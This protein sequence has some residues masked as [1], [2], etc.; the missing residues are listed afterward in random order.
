M[1][2]AVPTS[3][4]NGASPGE[5]DDDDDDDLELVTTTRASQSMLLPGGA[6]LGHQPESL[7]GSLL[8]ER[9]QLLRLIGQGGM[10]AVYLA[11]HVII[12]KQIAVKVLSP[13]YS[14][15]PADVQRFLGRRAPPR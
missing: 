6:E 10:G 9:Y 7:I 1:L 11:T 8:G 3:A 12:G 14:R 2:R 5:A 13:D 15:N 4:D